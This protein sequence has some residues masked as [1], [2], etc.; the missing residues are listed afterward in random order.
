MKKTKM[1]LAVLVGLSVASTSMA[2]T[3]SSAENK[4]AH[5]EVEEVGGL[6]FKLSLDNIQGKRADIKLVDAQGNL[7]YTEY[8]SSSKYTKVF[9]LAELNDG[10]YTFTVEN[11]N[12]KLTHKLEIATEVNRVVL[13]KNRK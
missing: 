3:V 1:I 5:L 11:G 8:A 2:Q 6:K 7:L 4:P 12:E 10:V 9:D 13:A